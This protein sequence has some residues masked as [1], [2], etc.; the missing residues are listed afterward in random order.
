MRYTINQGEAIKQPR[1]PEKTMKTA[2][3]K[4]RTWQ[5]KGDAAKAANMRKEWQAA[6]KQAKKIPSR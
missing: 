2:Q 5:W 3:T 1:Q 4:T 6:I